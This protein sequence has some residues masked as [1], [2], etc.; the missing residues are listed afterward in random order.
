MMANTVKQHG[1][2]IHMF[3]ELIEVVEHKMVI[4]IQR[5]EVGLIEMVDK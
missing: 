2:A 1:I 5:M 3:Q 4:G